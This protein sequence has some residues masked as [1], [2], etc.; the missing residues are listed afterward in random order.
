M[1]KKKYPA[2]KHPNSIANLRRA[3]D[4][5]PKNTRAAKHLAY[6]EDDKLPTREIAE[7]EA[8]IAAA[9]PVRAVD[10]DAPAADAAV[11]RLTAQVVVRQR[12][13]SDWLDRHGMFHRGK[14]RPVVEKLGT[15]ERQLADLLDSLGMTPRSRAKLGL[16]LV[17]TVSLAE[18][19]SEPEPERRRELLRQAG[20]VDGAK[21]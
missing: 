4:A 7:V 10:G 5:E 14:L 12:H 2:G 21:L 1:A 11:I 20:I 19:M 15:I 17:R 13:V 8:A 9:V 16:D 18:A 3:V 6:A